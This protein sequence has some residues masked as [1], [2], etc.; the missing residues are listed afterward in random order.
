MRYERI[1]R[2]RTVGLAWGVCLVAAG[3]GAAGRVPV[4]AMWS[5]F[6]DAVHAVVWRNWHVVGP[7][8]IAKV[9]GTSAENVAAMAQS[10]GLPPAIPIPPEQKSRGYFW[11]T[12][13]RRNWR[14][15][16]MDQLAALLET[17]WTLWLKHV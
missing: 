5:H 11:M 1:S 4:S 9:L 16:P 13:C 2:V 8:R 10:M 3:A 15:L 14:L 7:E 12:V 6:P 17:G